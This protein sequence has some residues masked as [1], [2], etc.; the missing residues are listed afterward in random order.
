MTKPFQ[1]KYESNL[2]CDDC[3]MEFDSKE[4]AEGAISGNLTRYIE[5]LCMMKLSGDI[6]YTDSGIQVDCWVSG[7]DLYAT[8]K[9]LWKYEGGCDGT[10]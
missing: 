2:G 8:W 4:E 10:T 3:I 1:V 7:S 6:W 9:R 5:E